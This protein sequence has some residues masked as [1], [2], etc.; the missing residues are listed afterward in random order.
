MQKRYHT[1]VK[2]LRSFF[3]IIAVL[4]GLISTA[5]A[6]TFNVTSS[7]YNATGN[8]VTNDYPAINAAIQ[9]AIAA[10]PGNT[11]YL[12]SG[13]YYVASPFNFG[14]ATNLTINGAGSSTELL[15]SGGSDIFDIWSCSGTT[16]SN[17]NIDEKTP[18][19][20]QGVI[21][22]INSSAKT[23]TVTINSGYLPP[24]NALFTT[25]SSFSPQLYIYTDPNRDTPDWN[26]QVN[27]VS[28]TTGSGGT[29]VL[30][31]GW[32]PPSTEIGKRFCIVGDN[33]NYWTFDI[34]ALN[35][36]TVSNV[37]CYSA[38]M[39]YIN[40]ATGTLN[41]TNDYWGP[42]PGSGRLGFYGGMQGSFRAALNMTGCTDI[43]TND[44]S[45]N[46]L[47][48]ISH[49]L[50]QINANTIQVPNGD[51]LPGDQ[52]AI[53]DYS[54][55]AGPYVRNVCTIASTA[56]VNSGADI[57]LTMTANV[58][59][60]HP[61]ND[62][63]SNL[64]TQ[65]TDGLDRMV[66]LSG[67]PITLTSCSFNSY[68]ARPLLLKSAQSITISNCTMYGGSQDGEEDGMETY[69]SEGPECNNLTVQNS[70]FY[71]NDG[72]NIDID[73]FG[74]ALNPVS[75]NQ[76]NINIT[77]NTF[78]TGGQHD[79]WNWL[80]PAGVGIRVDN[81]TNGTIK[82]N[83]FVG[84]S[85]AN[86]IVQT[87]NNVQ[88]TGN[89]F[90]NPHQQNL[91]ANGTQGTIDSGAT[92]FVDNAQ[93]VA[94][95]NNYVVNNGPYATNLITQ[96]STNTNVTGA[97]LGVMTVGSTVY[98][99]ENATLYGCSVVSESTASGGLAVGGINNSSD[100]VKFTVN[101]PLPGVYP[102]VVFYD[103]GS[104]GSS[105]PPDATQTV[106]VNGTNPQ[107]ITFPNTGG[108]NTYSSTNCQTIFV[109][110]AA[111][112]NT[113]QFNGATNYT[114][115]D[116][117]QV[118]NATTDLAL[119]VT[120]SGYPTPSASYTSPY[121]DSV[122]QAVD[123]VYSY[124]ATPHN[125]WTCYGSG[126]G[127]DWLEVN[128]GSPQTFN[129]VVLDIYADGSGVFAN[130]YNIQYSTNGTTWTNCASQSKSPSTPT[131][132]QGNIDTFTQVTAQYVRVVFTNTTQYSGV[133]EMEVY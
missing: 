15:S 26:E 65:Q 129:K 62:T 106:L 111:G 63:S 50:A 124:S 61:G 23:V 67:G 71:D 84:V 35:G 14:N 24:T 91:I 123:G 8:G 30:T 92:L 56:V 52:V 68:F 79:T 76:T 99:A 49:C 57:N 80:A 117:I 18:D 21:T 131:A 114:E 120:G 3:S 118:I 126:N 107:T 125:R 17:L 36:F 108:W 13:T 86:C 32:S 122:W 115:L 54:N 27:I 100:Y 87:D 70:T 6:T 43:M 10:G 98:Q 83:T 121:G 41:F 51:L 89:V 101:V 82:N 69:W 109:T 33:P 12:P 77:G 73:I 85:N 110:L 34:T 31:T 48:P 88:V 16:V 60:L 11:V 119:N 4:V 97:N 25:S 127:S 29:Y 74:T 28:A 44:D 42:P 40:G 9:A 102:V 1:S 112:N 39:I 103:N 46:A 2:V 38:A 72:P 90:L 81:V 104:T 7:P 5:M 105:R 128:F 22:A 96:T 64:T 47:T 20:T 59:L 45:M 95:A 37:N 116:Y 66:S 19:L 93:N 78:K 75:E 58:T 113:I 132:G 55:P 130:P 94:I 133:T 53:F